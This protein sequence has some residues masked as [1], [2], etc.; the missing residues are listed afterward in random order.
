MQHVGRFS[1]N[2]DNAN[3]MAKKKRRASNLRVRHH[4]EGAR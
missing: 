3:D 2:G 1:S 4:I